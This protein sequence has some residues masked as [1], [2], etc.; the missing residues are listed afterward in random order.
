MHQS[1]HISN[2][3]KIDFI[4]LVGRVWDVPSPW[5]TT[6]VCTKKPH[7]PTAS[8][9]H[10]KDFSKIFNKTFE[11]SSKIS[12][13][14]FLAFLDHIV[15]QKLGYTKKSHFLPLFTCFFATPRSLFS[16]GICY[17][18]VIFYILRS[19]YAIWECASNSKHVLL[20]WATLQVTFTRFMRFKLDFKTF[21]SEKMHFLPKLTPVLNTGHRS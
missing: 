21:F 8:D 16:T 20:P 9:C 10:E 7:K 1:I 12:K 18:F 15:A 3:E 4:W 5:S 11:K 19:N 14:I 6:F 2:F 13:N 17:F